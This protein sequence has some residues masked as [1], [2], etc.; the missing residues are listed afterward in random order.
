MTKQ[1]AKVPKGP[2]LIDE[3]VDEHGQPTFEIDDAEGNCVARYC[4]DLPTAQLLADSWEMRQVLWEFVDDAESRDSAH[5]YDLARRARELLGKYR[6]DVYVDHRGWRFRPPFHCFLCGIRVSLRQ[7]C[8]SRS[9]G[10]CDVSHSR[11]ARLNPMSHR[12][13]AGPH[14]RLDVKG[15]H[16]INPEWLDPA[17]RDSYQPI[18]RPTIQRQPKP[19]SPPIPR[20]PPMRP[21]PPLKRFPR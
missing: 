9:C 5:W 20:K 3:Y 19:P 15:L 10:G 13:F 18:Y 7:F 11:T 8:F 17:D 1:P 12:V 14:E 4:P 21:M 16:D 6:M 2:F